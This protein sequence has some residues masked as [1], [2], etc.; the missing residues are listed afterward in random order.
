VQEELGGKLA[1]EASAGVYGGDMRAEEVEE[2][3]DAEEVVYE[4]EAEPYDREMS[5]EAVEPK[6]LPYEDRSLPI[7]NAEDDLRALVSLLSRGENPRPRRFR[8]LT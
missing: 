4:E 1:S 2:D 8:V 3:A 5:P 6:N 7:V